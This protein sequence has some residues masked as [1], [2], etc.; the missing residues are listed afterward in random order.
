[1]RTGRLRILLADAT[2]VVVDKPSGLL[3]VP[4]DGTRGQTCLQEIRREHPAARAVHRL[5]RDTS[6]VLLFALSEPAR[7]D[8]ERQFRERTVK[9]VYLALVR[10][11]PGRK[12]GIIDKPIVDLGKTAAVRRDGEQALTQ[13][14]VIE[15]VGPASLVRVEP[16]TGRYNQIRLHFAAIGHP[17]IGER[18]Y[19]RGRDSV[20]RASRVALHA[21]SLAFT[22]PATQ[23]RIEVSAPLPDSW[24]VLMERLRGLRGI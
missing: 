7:L 24:R 6:G 2:I 19:A 21:Q 1:M 13:Y 17:L 18:K 11:R 20:I 5:D 10:G 14:K 9:K 22:H 16:K 3:S 12:S 15:T 4:S 8:L 23:A